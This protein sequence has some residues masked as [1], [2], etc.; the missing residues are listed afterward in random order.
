MSVRSRSARVAAAV[1]LIGALSLAGC[2]SPT[3]AAG[4]GTTPAATEA[5]KPVAI[6]IGTLAT[7]DSLP[8]WVAEEKGYFA[9]AQLPKVEIITFQSAQECQA[10]FTAGAVDALMTDLIVA[11][12]LQASGTKV[13]VP[14]VMLGADTAQGRFAVVAAPKSGLTSMTDLKGVPVGTAAAT[15]T[16]YVL[17]KL[18]EEAG[19]AASDIK[20]EEVAKMPVRFELLMSGKLKAASLPEPFVSLAVQG[21]AKVVQGGD[22][23]LAKEN[24]SQSVLCVNGAFAATPDGAATVKAL[25]VAWDK[26][27][28]A[29]NADPNS[30]RPTLVDKARLPQ[31]LAQSYQVS[32]YPM[33]APPA[34]ADVQR[35]LDWMKTKGYLKAEVTPADL[36]P[37]K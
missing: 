22:D 30:F 26:A 1:V 3:P 6:R 28:G 35:V 13:T 14:T 29:I 23:T 10:A 33:A 12:K 9:E 21:G 32:S 2:T 5:S 4:P 18:G 34:A 36:L 16:E 31:P 19:L 7:Q 25:L 20:T 8:L 15:I 11:A 27:A 17:D 24:L 37:A